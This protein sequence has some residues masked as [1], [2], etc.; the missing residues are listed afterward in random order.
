[1]LFNKRAS[2]EISIQAI[3]IVV[4]AMTLL[5]LGLGF[6]KGLFGNIS[7][8]SAA[9]F[10]KISDQLSRDLVN[11]NEKLVFSQT[12]INIERGKSILLGWGIKN[13]GNARLDYYAEFTPITCPDSSGNPSTCP[14]NAIENWFTYKPR[15]GANPTPYSVDAAGQQVERLDLT[16]PKRSNIDPGL[17]LIEL[18]IKDNSG[19]KYATTDIFVT[20]T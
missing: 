1:M 17:Y 20:V 18:A 14:S 2:L 6:I 4:L 10:D 11:G 9:T 7:S 15:T 13:D 12:K 5:G 16:I 19:I 8:L 3:V